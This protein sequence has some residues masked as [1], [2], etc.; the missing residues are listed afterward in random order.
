MSEDMSEGR[1]K[2]MS[3]GMS[4]DMSERMP[5]DLSE[6]LSEDM[7]ERLSEDMSGSCQKMSERMS[8]VRRYVRKFVCQVEGNRKQRRQ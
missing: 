3:E 7:S 2:D 5:K 1:S 4:K 6:R 8:S